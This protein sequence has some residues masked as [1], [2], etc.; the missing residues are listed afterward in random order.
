MAR[1][2]RR[3]CT[4]MTPTEVRVIQRGRCWDT[5]N[6]IISN[7]IALCNLLLRT[8]DPTRG[9]RILKI[10]KYKNSIN[11]EWNNEFAYK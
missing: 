7:N 6:R 10:K 3:S 9:T 2:H 11:N 8:N 5:E 4:P 1:G